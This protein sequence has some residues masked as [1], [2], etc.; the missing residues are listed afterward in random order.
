M[1]DLPRIL[2]EKLL[3][4]SCWVPASL[5]REG[6][7]CRTSPTP[8]VASPLCLGCVAFSPCNPR[9][10]SLFTESGLERQVTV[11]P[12]SQGG[13]RTALTFLHS[14]DTCQQGPS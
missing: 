10:L 13:T 14:R 8:T 3:S 2:L 4:G 12:V 1:D 9:L 11:E 5:C 7:F 6:T